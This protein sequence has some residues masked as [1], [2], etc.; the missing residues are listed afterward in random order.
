MAHLNLVGDGDE[1]DAVEEIEAE[2]SI[3][4]D[5]SD[6]GDWWTV[7]DLFEAVKRALPAYDANQPSTWPRF[8]AALCEISCDDPAEITPGMLLIMP[9]G[10]SVWAR[11]GDALRK[12]TKVRD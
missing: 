12:I 2:F 6:A 4:L 1:I 7:A 8:C 11:V 9:A 5:T 10:P 3:T